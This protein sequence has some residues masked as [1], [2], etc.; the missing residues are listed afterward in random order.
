MGEV[1]TAAVTV[2]DMVAKAATA[3]VEDMVVQCTVVDIKADQ[4]VM[5]R[6]ADSKEATAVDTVVTKAVVMEAVSAAQVAVEAA[7]AVVS[8][9]ADVAEEVVAV[10]AIHHTERTNE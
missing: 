9:A 8:E 7:V 6:E 5:A 3:V 4:V 10:V 1:A 2:V